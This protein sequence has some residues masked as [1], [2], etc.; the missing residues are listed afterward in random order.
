MRSF[1]GDLEGIIRREE[2]ASTRHDRTSTTEIECLVLLYIMGAQDI[3]PRLAKL[4]ESDRTTGTERKGIASLSRKMR[5]KEPLRWE[6]VQIIED[7]E[8]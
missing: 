1:A 6:D 4:S 8:W 7:E 3:P 5:S 2:N